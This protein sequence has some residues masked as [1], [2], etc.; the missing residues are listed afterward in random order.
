V[1]RSAPLLVDWALME[2]EDGALERARELLAKAVKVGQHS[3][4]AALRIGPA[5]IP[6]V[7]SLVSTLD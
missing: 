3:L 1:G 7:R 6:V 2:A 5:T 4:A